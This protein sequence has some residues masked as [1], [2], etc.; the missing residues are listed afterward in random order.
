MQHLTLP[1][2]LRRSA[3]ALVA[4]VLPLVATA[5]ASAGPIQM[6][7]GHV[8]TD[9]STPSPFDDVEVVLNSAGFALTN[10]FLHDSFAFVGTPNPAFVLLGPGDAVEF[11]G[12]ATLV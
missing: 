11:S 4:V 6:T 9:D 10:E 5:G 8:H 7:S 2:N 3:I 12:H 1:A